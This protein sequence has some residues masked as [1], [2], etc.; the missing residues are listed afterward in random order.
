L[1][2]KQLL[3]ANCEI[4]FGALPYRE[5]EIWDMTGDNYKIITKLGF[6][7][8]YDLSNLLINM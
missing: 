1:Q 2:C 4:E 7:T 5:N 8:N 6:K 3:K